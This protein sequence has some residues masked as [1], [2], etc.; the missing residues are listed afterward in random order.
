MILGFGSSWSFGLVRILLI[1]AYSDLL[2]LLSRP[3]KVEL[4]SS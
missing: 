1:A 3:I 4:S 2:L